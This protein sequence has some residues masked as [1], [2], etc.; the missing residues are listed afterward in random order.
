MSSQQNPISGTLSSLVQWVEPR[1]E[2][3]SDGIDMISG[4][5]PPGVTAFQTTRSGGDSVGGYASFNLA[6]H[7]GD[8]EEL[9]LQNR[10]RLA[11]WH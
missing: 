9:I 1:F 8:R 6:S 10:S 11:H 2:L 7:V 4:L 3:I 5:F